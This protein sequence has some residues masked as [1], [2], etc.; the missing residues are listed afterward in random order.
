MSG[1]LVT[2]ADLSAEDAS[3]LHQHFQELQAALDE[4][5]PVFRNL[6]GIIKDVLLKDPTLV[7]HMTPEEAAL[8]V[9]GASRATNIFLEEKA[10][11]APK[12]KVD[13]S[14]MDF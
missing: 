1:I 2:E 5:S 14:K 3:K 12:K 11:A 10:K 7:T 6:L 9:K 4:S 8:I 13:Y